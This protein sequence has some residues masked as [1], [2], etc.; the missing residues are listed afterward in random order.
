[1]KRAQAIYIY[2]SSPACMQ[3][4]EAVEDVKHL[5]LYCPAYSSAR[6][7][8]FNALSSL[9][10]QPSLELLL[11]GYHLV[12]KAKRSAVSSILSLFLSAINHIRKFSI[13]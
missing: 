13:L 3:C 8:A 12:A 4:N 10:I 5:L 2:I 7:I 11:G 6:S 9:H 1:M